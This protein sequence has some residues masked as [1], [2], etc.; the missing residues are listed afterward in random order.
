MDISDSIAPKSDQL[1]AEDLLA[2]PLTFTIDRVTKGS[3]EQPYNFHLVEL[4]GRAYRPSKSM[5]RVIVAA[6]GKQTEPYAGRRLTVYRDPDVKF[7]GQPVGGI[8]ISHLSHIDKA[9]TIWLTETRGVRKP[10]EVRPLAEQVRGSSVAE[11]AAG[12]VAAFGR[13]GVTQE[14][15][16]TRVKKYVT[17]WNEA[18]LTELG[19]VFIAVREK[20]TT[21]EDEFVVEETE[22][23]G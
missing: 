10:H 7:G 9:M 3:A 1:N 2:G 8:K 15:L 12:L 13:G 11:R 21:V 16:E 17:D 19:D 23:E 14:Q 4:P 22:P 20:Q 18:E 6:W 5:R